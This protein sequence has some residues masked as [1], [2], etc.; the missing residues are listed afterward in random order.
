MVYSYIVTEHIS[1]SLAR[2]SSD[3][4]SACFK[5]GTEVELCRLIPVPLKWRQTG[6]PL[7]TSLQLFEVGCVIFNTTFFGGLSGDV[8]DTDK[9]ASD[10][11][12]LSEPPQPSLSPE[13]PTRR[14]SL[15]VAL[16]GVIESW[17]PAT[18]WKSSCAAELVLR[19]RF[20]LAGEAHGCRTPLMSSRYWQSLLRRSSN[21]WHSWL[22]VGRSLGASH[23]H[24]D[25]RSYLQR[26]YR[27]RRN[28]NCFSDSKILRNFYRAQLTSCHSQFIRAVDRLFHAI[29]A[30][31]KWVQVSKGYVWVWRGTCR[32]DKEEG[33]HWTHTQLCAPHLKHEMS[34]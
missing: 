8:I 24:C 25:I 5:V 12:S 3:W 23:Q 2:W 34:D 18:I 10:E 13:L 6:S 19:L 16:E 11:S 21:C 28:L 1:L 22:K 14:K 15:S 26:W 31:Q 29:P 17:L 9:P 33:L 20:S 7:V 27:G 32:Q 4:N 30:R